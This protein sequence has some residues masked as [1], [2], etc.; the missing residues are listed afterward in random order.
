VDRFCRKGAS[1]GPWRAGGFASQSHRWEEE[2]GSLPGHANR[3]EERLSGPSNDGHHWQKH[4]KA[5]FC[6]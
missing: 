5:L 6:Y 1:I 3:E 4:V 2:I